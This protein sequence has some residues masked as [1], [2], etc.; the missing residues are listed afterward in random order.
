M[1][2]IKKGLRTSGVVFFINIVLAVSKVAAGI[3]GNSNALVAD[4]IESTADSITA[5]IVWIGLR[6]SARPPDSTHPYGHG[7]AE[8]ISALVVSLFVLGAAG[9]IAFQSIRGISSPQTAPA[10]YTLLVLVAVIVIKETMFRKINNISDEIHS[11]ALKSDAWHHRSDAITS[12]AAF[13]GISI[14]LIGGKGYEVAD[15]WA[16]LAACLVIAFNGARLV[17]TALNDVMDAAPPQETQDAVRRIAKE[18]EA[19]VDVE[20]CR[21]RK[22]GL[23]LLLDIHV[24][25]DGDI[26][27]RQGHD[28]AH[29]VQ[30]R[31]YHTLPEIR[32]VVVHIEPHD[33]GTPL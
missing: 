14:A 16:A 26:T 23:G 11:G 19:V 32:D 13:V 21:V 28:I 10:P 5:M 22:S 27:V 1:E 30:D 6:I 15:D 20:K 31:L 33:L 24:V 9:L 2:P 12:L 29:Q 25:V 8:S 18:T 7:K 17:S 4:G 3:L